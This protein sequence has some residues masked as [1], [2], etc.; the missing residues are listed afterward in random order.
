MANDTVVKQSNSSVLWE[1]ALIV[2]ALISKPSWMSFKYVKLRKFPEFLF[3]DFCFFVLV[4]IVGPT[5]Y[6]LEDTRMGYS[7]FL[8]SSN[9]SYTT[10]YMPLTASLIHSGRGWHFLICLHICEIWE[11]R[12]LYLEE[13]FEI[14]MFCNAKTMIFCVWMKHRPKFAEFWS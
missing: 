1:T 10:P 2:E 6:E 3:W 4:G 12:L 5:L 9:R 7:F 14:F 11:R 8:I 13:W